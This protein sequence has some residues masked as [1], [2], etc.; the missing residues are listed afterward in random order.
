MNTGKVNIIF[1]V[2]ALVA[3]GGCASGPSGYKANDPILS[4]A[5]AR[6]M[7]SVEVR[8]LEPLPV[9]KAVASN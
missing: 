6:S 4:A 7:I 5:D 1:V 8:E 3:L 9:E 2:A